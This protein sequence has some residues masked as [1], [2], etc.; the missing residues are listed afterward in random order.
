MKTLNPCKFSA[1]PERTLK[2]LNWHVISLP[3]NDG[4]APSPASSRHS[5]CCPECRR[6]DDY[7]SLSNE[8]LR[9]AVDLEVIK[10]RSNVPCLRKP[11][12]STRNK[13]H[14]NLF[15]RDVLCVFARSNEGTGTGMHIIPYKR[16]SGMCSTILISEHWPLAGHSGFASSN[17]RPNYQDVE[18]L[19]NINYIR[20]G[21]FPIEII[22]R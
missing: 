20:N 3:E 1:T 11:R 21:M 22:H 15:N 6:K 9:Q 7:F 16:G 4:K 8:Y 14:T 19:I 17:N 12:I 2:I 5:Q 10:E 18:D 13:F